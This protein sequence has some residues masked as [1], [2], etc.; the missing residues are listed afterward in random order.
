MNTVQ[1]IEKNFEKALVN[2]NG[3]I[4]KP[5]LATISVF[6]RSFLY[7][8]SVYEVTRSYGGKI[9]ALDEHLERLWN[10]MEILSL[11][12]TISQSELTQEIL[13]TFKAFAHPDCYIRI[14]ITRG[15]GEIGLDISKVH[16]NNVVIIIKEILPNP[17]HWYTHGVDYIVAKTKRMPKD[18]LNPMAKTGNYLNSILALLEAKKLGAF[19][20]LLLDHEGYVTEGS[21]NNIWMVKNNKV[22]TPSSERG[23]L[24]GITRDFILSFHQKSNIEIQEKDFFLDELLAADE[25]FMTSSLKEV[26]P[27]IK[28]DQMIIG[29]GKPGPMTQKLHQLYQQAINN[30]ITKGTT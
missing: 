18:S 10:S 29:K 5:E 17:A 1:Y 16:H 14:I 28:I 22:F 20:A 24:K 4:L 21:T 27:I 9:F 3:E 25:V 6:D 19:D 23:I 7:G 15:V 8:D 2:V 11:K 26:V 13:K 30:F 12:P